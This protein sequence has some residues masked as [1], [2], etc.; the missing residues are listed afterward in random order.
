M[1]GN[2]T[3]GMLGG[4]PASQ[5][6]RRRSQQIR[7]ADAPHCHVGVIALS[8]VVMRFER[9][10]LV[11]ASLTL[12]RRRRS[13]PVGSTSDQLGRVRRRLSAHFINSKPQCGLS[14]FAVRDPLS[15]AVASCRQLRTG[16]VMGG[17]FDNRWGRATRVL[18]LRC[19]RS[20]AVDGVHH[21][22]SRARPDLGL[23][24]AQLSGIRGRP[25]L[26]RFGVRRRR[27]CGGGDAALRPGFSCCRC[28]PAAPC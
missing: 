20:D 4:G 15:D 13:L 18:G 23:R 3:R 12:T 17:L 22:F 16:I 14:L 8:T 11:L 1:G 9:V 28:W 2:A 21:Q 26:D 10:A 25:V 24:H 19:E 7:E 5:Y 6:P 27:W